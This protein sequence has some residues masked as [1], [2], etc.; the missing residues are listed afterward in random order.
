MAL[1]RVE[2]LN[3]DPSRGSLSA[4]LYGVARH[5]VL[6]C[7]ERD[8]SYVPLAD[9]AEEENAHALEHTI[10]SD[11]LAHNF[12]RKEMIEQLH[13]AIDT[14]PA[15]YRE[16]IVLC[17][18]HELSYA[19]AAVVIECAIGTVRSRLHRARALLAE[20]LRPASRACVEG[21]GETEESSRAINPVGCLI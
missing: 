7:L 5:H 20:K 19:E 4:Y 13:A 1:V 6:R 21:S 8:K 3:Y 2:K 17:D 11:D 15:H 14:L 18:L 12:A 10:A 16:V 9:E